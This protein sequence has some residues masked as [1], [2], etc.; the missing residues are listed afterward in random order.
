MFFY[1][2]SLKSDLFTEQTLLL[3]DGYCLQFLEIDGEFIPRVAPWPSILLPK[4]EG[5]SLARLS[6]VSVG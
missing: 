6:Y 4:G 3:G 2:L 5:N 1:V